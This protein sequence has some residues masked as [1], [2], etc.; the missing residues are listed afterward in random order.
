MVIHLLGGDLELDWN[1]ANDRIAIVA[2]APASTHSGATTDTE[3]QW[4]T[5]QP[6]RGSSRWQ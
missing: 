3:R 1:A 6:L 4:A 2:Q 5:G